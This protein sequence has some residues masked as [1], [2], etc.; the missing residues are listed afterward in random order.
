MVILVFIYLSAIVLVYYE[1]HNN[2]V[3]SH[4]HTFM[5]MVLLEYWYYEDDINIPG[6]LH[7]F[8]PFF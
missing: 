6:T 7:M 8:I 1:D 5:Y 4:F 3:Y 2:G